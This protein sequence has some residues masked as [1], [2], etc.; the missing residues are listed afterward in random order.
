MFK[1]RKQFAEEGGEGTA[2]DVMNAFT[3]V[4]THATELSPRMRDTLARMGGMLAFG[5]SR[6]CPRCWSLSCWASRCS[7]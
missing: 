2:Y 7:R 5:H 4:A 6:L 3:R 1:R